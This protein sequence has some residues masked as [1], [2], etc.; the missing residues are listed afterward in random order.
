MAAASAPAGTVG[1]ATTVPTGPVPQTAGT[2]KP[3]LKTNF[4]RYPALGV[5][6]LYALMALAFAG[7]AHIYAAP[8][9]SAHYET[10]YSTINVERSVLYPC[11]YRYT[12]GNF[13]VPFSS[14]KRINYDCTSV[15]TYSTGAVGNTTY[16]GPWVSGSTLN[17][18][19]QSNASNGTLVYSHGQACNAGNCPIIHHVAVY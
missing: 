11:D 5:R 1:F 17:Y 4:K 7:G 12:H 3:N 18:W 14:A 9:A 13:Y 6:L 15:G 8:S 10:Y 16:N 2:I 19:Y